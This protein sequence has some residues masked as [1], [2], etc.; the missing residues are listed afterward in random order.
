MLPIE[1]AEDV[2]KLIWGLYDSTDEYDDD[3][4]TTTQT[5]AV[6]QHVLMKM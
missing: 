2:G 1:T 4:R 5:Y 3:V 6:S